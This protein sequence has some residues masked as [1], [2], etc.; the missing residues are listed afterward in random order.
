VQD[1][2]GSEEVNGVYRRKGIWYCRAH[3]D[4]EQC[5]QCGVDYRLVNELY[6]ENVGEEVDATIRKEQERL[7]DLELQ[8]NLVPPH[9]EPAIEEAAHPR[10]HVHHDPA[11]TED[12]QSIAK[13]LEEEL[14]RAREKEKA[15]FLNCFASVQIS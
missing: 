13:D 6:R 10:T 15:D 14:D 3:I 12:F 4:R 9:P 5:E 1:S 2:D 11:D 7:E 8:R